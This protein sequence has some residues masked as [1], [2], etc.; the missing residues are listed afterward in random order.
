MAN[1][2]AA[3]LH[4]QVFALLNYNRD[5]ISS[6]KTVAAIIHPS[7]YGGRSHVLSTRHI[8]LQPRL[9]ALIVRTGVFGFNTTSAP[10]S[11]TRT[12][13]IRCTLGYLC[14]ARSCWSCPGAA[15][16]RQTQSVQTPPQLLACRI[17]G[18]YVTHR[19]SSL[20][21]DIREI[22]IG[23]RPIVF[24]SVHSLPAIIRPETRSVPPRLFRHDVLNSRRHSGGRTIGALIAP[25]PKQVLS[26]FISE[27]LALFET[28]RL[29]SFGL[30]SF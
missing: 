14:R 30:W 27:Q 8:C 21:L 2:C 19:E 1:N 17:D 16:Q 6:L 4:A 23:G 13:S 22:R 29:T 10:L 7:V 28:P 9:K 18:L 5:H 15:L 11:P 25:L 26:D 12:A 24:F 20:L 3:R